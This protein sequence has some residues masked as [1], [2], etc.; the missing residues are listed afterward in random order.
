MLKIFIVSVEI[1]TEV[2]ESE[3]GRKN[4]KK[5]YAALKLEFYKLRT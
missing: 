2:T 1:L 3:H 4:C 5:D